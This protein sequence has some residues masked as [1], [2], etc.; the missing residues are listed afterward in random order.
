MK[1]IKAIAVAFAAVAAAG[2]V[3]RT[4][5]EHGMQGYEARRE[6][7]RKLKQQQKKRA[8]HNKKH[9]PRR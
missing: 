5:L 1:Q 7:E 9:G 6:K 2:I 4:G 8:Q 3:I